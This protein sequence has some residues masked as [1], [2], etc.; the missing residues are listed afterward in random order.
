MIHHE[1]V[2][3]LFASHGTV[4]IVDLGA[5]QTVMGCHQQEEISIQL[6][7]REMAVPTRVDV[8]RFGNNGT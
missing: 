1:P 4:G 3:I 2:D 6:P 5:S 7:R 8:I